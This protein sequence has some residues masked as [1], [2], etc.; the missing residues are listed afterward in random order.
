[1]GSGGVGRVGNSGGVVGVEGSENGNRRV[2]RGG[3]SGS[4]SVSD[5]GM[6]WQVGVRDLA[7]GW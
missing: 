5:S 1:M 3:V 2:V 6:E 4:G 7:V